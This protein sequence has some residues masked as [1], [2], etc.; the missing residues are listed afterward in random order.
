MSTRESFPFAC[1]TLR[2]LTS[3]RGRTLFHMSN[4]RRPHYASNQG[5]HLYAPNQGSIIPGYGPNGYR[6]PVPTNSRGLSSYPPYQGGS[7]TPGF[8]HGY[9][10]PAQGFAYESNPSRHT[11]I[12][13]RR[14][15]QGY[16]D[17]APTPVNEEDDEDSFV[18]RAKRMRMSGQ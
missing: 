13:H 16:G 12:I 10:R 6:T 1:Q 18:R 11:D 17:Q 2:I 7:Y 5:A 15:T 4:E 9:E 3:L 8:G 14:E